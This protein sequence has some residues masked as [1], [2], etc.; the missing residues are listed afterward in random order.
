MAIVSIYVT[1]K[2]SILDVQGATALRALESLGY[3]EVEDVRIGKFI[4]LE[5]RDE[6]EER[7][8]KRVEEMCRRLLANPIIE[9]YR[10]EIKGRIKQG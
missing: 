9:D 8:S 2:P 7:L 1:L 6:N 4:T 10:F 5:V 3:N